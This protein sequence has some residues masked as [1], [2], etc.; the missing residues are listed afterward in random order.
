MV[1]VVFLVAFCTWQV[2]ALVHLPGVAPQNFVD[3]EDVPLKV[4]KLTS[5]HTQLPYLYYSLPFCTPKKII[6]SAENLG[7]ILRGDRIEN[8][9]YSVCTVSHRLVLCKYLYICWIDLYL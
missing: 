7:E 9:E 5:V 3:L 1:S 6:D 2:R 8:S 4:N